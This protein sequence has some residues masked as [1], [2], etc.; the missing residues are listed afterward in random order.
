[1]PVALRQFSQLA[2]LGVSLL[3]PF[4]VIDL[5]II[6]LIRLHGFAWSQRILYSIILTL[7]ETATPSN[8]KIEFYQI[9]EP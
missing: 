2:A 3:K 4:P 9:N 1:M 7:E 8:S 6:V 5:Q